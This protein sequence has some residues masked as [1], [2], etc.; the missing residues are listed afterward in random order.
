MLLHILFKSTLPSL[1]MGNSDKANGDNLETTKYERL[2][3]CPA[4]FAKIFNLPFLKFKL[5]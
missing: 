1:A 3:T 2:I 4:K 5:K